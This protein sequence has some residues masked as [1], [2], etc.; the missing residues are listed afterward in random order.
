M[1]FL[2]HM[3]VFVLC[4]WTMFSISI[5][6]NHFTVCIYWLPLFCTKKNIH[7]IHEGKTLFAQENTHL[8]FDIRNSKLTILFNLF[9]V[10]SALRIWLSC[11]DVAVYRLIL[12]L[13]WHRMV[14]GTS[15][16][17]KT[18]NRPTNWVKMSTEWLNMIFKQ[19]SLMTEKW[20]L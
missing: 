5:W 7:E 3:S 10:I 4:L 1:V 17:P 2:H 15:N 12:Y 6:S 16:R 13:K 9:G 18:T 19:D 14:L 8:L 20:K 11:S